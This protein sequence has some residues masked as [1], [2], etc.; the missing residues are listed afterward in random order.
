VEAEQLIRRSRAARASLWGVVLTDAIAIPTGIVYARYLQS[1][2]PTA[3]IEELELVASELLDALVSLTQLAA[4]IVAAVCFIRWFHLAHLNLR[5]LSDKPIE[6]DSRWTI[7]GFFVPILNLIRPQQLMRE[8]WTISSDRWREASFRVVGLTRPTDLVNLWW[9]FFVLTS[10][11]GNAVG[12]ASLKAT[13]A[14]ETLWAAWSTIFANAFDM[15][16]ALVALALVRSVTQLQRPLIG[17]SRSEPDAR[18][19]LRV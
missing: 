11:I 7:W 8:I 12:R 13:T 2:N 1:I 19:Q 10:L 17:D 6:N 14:Q 4:L 3:V 16:A 9:G 15:V 18:P 5:I